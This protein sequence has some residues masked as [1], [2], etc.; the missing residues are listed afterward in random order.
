MKTNQK[1]IKNLN[2]FYNILNW[3]KS[4]DLPPKTHKT[5][6]LIMISLLLF[7]IP[8]FYIWILAFFRIQ[9]Y[10]YLDSLFPLGFISFITLCPGL[11]SLWISIC[12]W[13]RIKGYNWNMIPFFD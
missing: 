13:R 3:V 8:S 6:M 2:P 11:Y 10:D 7:G 1:T 5:S 4:G 9:F 12:C